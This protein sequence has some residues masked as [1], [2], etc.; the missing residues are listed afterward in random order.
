MNAIKSD[1]DIINELIELLENNN[2]TDIIQNVPKLV[3]FM[4]KNY[5]TFERNI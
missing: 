3:L 1:Q 5:T 2:E 4:E